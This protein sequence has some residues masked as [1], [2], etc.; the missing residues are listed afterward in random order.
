MPTVSSWRE[1]PMPPSPPRNLAQRSA[2]GLSS[3]WGR[4]EDQISDSKAISEHVISIS[5]ASD[6]EVPLK[7]R[8]P[9][10]TTASIVPSSVK[11]G[12]SNKMIHTGIPV[13]ATPGPSPMTQENVKALQLQMLQSDLQVPKAPLPLESSAV[14][15]PGASTSLYQAIESYEL[16]EKDQELSKTDINLMILLAQ[17][18]DFNEADYHTLLVKRFERTP[19]EAYLLAKMA[20]AGPRA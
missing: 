6:V 8:T 3:L 11:A 16:P 20:A 19:H 17:S 13:A 12:E 2:S 18:E 9:T 10:S 5:L 1:T 15:T 4:L 7:Y 14:P